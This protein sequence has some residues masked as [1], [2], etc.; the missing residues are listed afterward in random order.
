VKAWNESPWAKDE[1]RDYSEVDLDLS[2]LEKMA[3]KKSE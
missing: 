3:E 1:E 2:W